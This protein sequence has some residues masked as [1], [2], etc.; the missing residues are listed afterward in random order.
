MPPMEHR[1]TSATRTEKWHFDGRDWNRASLHLDSGVADTTEIARGFRIAAASGEPFTTIPDLRDALRGVFDTIANAGHRAALTIRSHRRIVDRDGRSDTAASDTISMTIRGPREC[2]AS[3]RLSGAEQALA[4]I[5]PLAADPPLLA[6]DARDYPIVWRN[7]SAAVLLHEAIGHPGE[8]A[9]EAIHW[10]AWL[11]VSDD[12][13]AG[14][15]GTMPVDDVGSQTSRRIISGGEPPSAQRRSGYRDVPLRR[16][17]NVVARHDDDAFDEPVPRLEVFLI[18]RGHYDA[19]RD[20]VELRIDVADV[21][22]GEGR[23]AIAPFV[24]VER[25]DSIAMRLAGAR[26]EAVDYPGV[27][28]SREGQR[29]AVGSVAPELLTDAFAS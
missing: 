23:V 29:L 7:G 1:Y 24:M 8:L 10:P 15:I 17:T 9:S 5:L 26:G 20:S 4:A 16:L 14:G 28:C 2:S 12:P 22:T 27:I 13:S 25:R 18:G 3:T 21:V 19:L 11:E 6:V